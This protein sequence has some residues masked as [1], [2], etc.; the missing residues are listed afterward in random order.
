MVF[1][2]RV[3]PF[4]RNFERSLKV[5]LCVPHMCSAATPKDTD[6]SP[7]CPVLV[8]NNRYLLSTGGQAHSTQTLNTSPAVNGSITVI[9]GL[10]VNLPLWLFMLTRTNPQILGLIALLRK[11]PTKFMFR[12]ALLYK[13]DSTNRHRDS[14]GAGF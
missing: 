3:S 11:P 7:L 6:C 2:E 8:R 13:T 5:S 9:D 10:H 12:L 14:T 1:S 4:E